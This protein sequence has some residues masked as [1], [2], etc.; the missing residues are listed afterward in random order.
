MFNLTSL[1]FN[2]S[3]SI[4][5]EMCY[6]LFIALH[7]H[8]RM[9]VNTPVFAVLFRYLFIHLAII[10]GKFTFIRDTARMYVCMYIH[11]Y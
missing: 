3:H 4:R 5:E 10:R 2:C 11:I 6:V 9:N 8:V 7:A 1:V